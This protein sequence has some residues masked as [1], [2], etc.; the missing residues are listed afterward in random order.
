VLADLVWQRKAHQNAF[1]CM[2]PIDLDGDAYVETTAKPLI[3]VADATYFAAEPETARN[4]SLDRMSLFMKIGEEFLA[5]LAVC[6]GMKEIR[7]VIL[8]C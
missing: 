3:D 6:Q 8:S 5:L 7:F 2:F 4:D 1:L